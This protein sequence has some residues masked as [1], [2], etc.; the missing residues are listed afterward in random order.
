MAF[1]CLMAGSEA[2]APLVHFCGFRSWPQVLTP[3]PASDRMRRVDG[4]PRR[5]L[6]RRS[7][8]MHC[9]PAWRAI[10]S[11]SSSSSTVSSAPSTC[12]MPT[13]RWRACK[14]VLNSRSRKV[15]VKTTRSW[16]KRTTATTVPR[17][18]RS[19]AGS[20]VF[21]AHSLTEA[22][23]YRVRPLARAIQAKKRLAEED[24]GADAAAHGGR[25]G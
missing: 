1:W 14:L 20:K 6:R 19:E 11:S 23:I 22:R 10:L 15:S 21:A 2:H 17:R 12:R 13:A 24:R 7:S 3:T 9:A 4:L 18:M 25:T 8:D 16:S 5:L